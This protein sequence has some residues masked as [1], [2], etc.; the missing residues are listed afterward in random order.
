[1]SNLLIL[2]LLVVAIAIGW[3]L[4]RLSKP[5]RP[6]DSADDAAHFLSRDY[7]AGLNF[8]LSDQSDRA[9]DNFVNSLEVSNNTI[10]THI[11]L[12]NLFR[13]RGEADRG[14][15]LHQNL[16]ARPALSER[17]NDQV[18]LELARDFMHLGVLDRAERL[19]KSIIETTQ[20]GD[21]QSA[22]RQLLIKLFEQEKEWQQAIDLVPEHLIREH[23][24]LRKAAAHW[25]CEL[26]QTHFNHGRTRDALKLLK[27]AT[28]IDAQCVRAY[29]LK[30][31]H[32]HRE[33]RYKDEIKT[34][35]QISA[36]E[37]AY[38]PLILES[39][40]AAYRQLGDDAGLMRFLDQQIEA[41]QHVSA[42]LARAELGIEQEGLQAVLSRI[43][44]CQERYPSLR[45]IRFQ[46][47]LYARQVQ[48][49]FPTVYGDTSANAFKRLHHHLEQLEQHTPYFRCEH[50]GFSTSHLY[51][52]CPQCRSWSTI[53]PRETLDTIE[54]QRQTPAQQILDTERTSS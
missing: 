47:L 22:A 35:K 30:A 9:I 51:W 3:V 4:G 19:L 50:C 46:T 8:L 15:R 40:M 28:S 49:D 24:E 20:Y 38:A 33:G 5:S 6:D 13:L 26:A 41:T 34:L 10:D 7:V 12:G 48:A 43:D 25:H 16:L 54:A 27:R 32:H 18:Q 14:V 37:P 52:H 23:D 39:V 11:T 21:I 45:G 53:K 42:I 17:Q 31:G 36:H 1:M 2:V 29:W 44:A